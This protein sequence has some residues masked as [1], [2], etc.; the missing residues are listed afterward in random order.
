MDFPGF[1]ALAIGLIL[2][3]ALREI[4]LRLRRLRVSRAA[5]DPLEA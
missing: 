5:R 3:V 2:F 4:G 1:D